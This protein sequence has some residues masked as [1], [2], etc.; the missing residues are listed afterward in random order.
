[1]NHQIFSIDQLIACY[2]PPNLRSV[3][4][5]NKVMLRS[6]G[7]EMTVCDTNAQGQAVCQWMGA[8]GLTR[9]VFDLECLTC[10]GAR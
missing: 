5:G 4:P 3:M 10:Y 6:G 9:S 2:A 1:M 7:P 8:D